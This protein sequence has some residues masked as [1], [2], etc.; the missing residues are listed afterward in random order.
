MPDS[1]A[2]SEQRIARL[3]LRNQMAGQRGIAVRA[4]AVYQDVR[5]RLIIGLL[6]GQ[7]APADQFLHIGMVGGAKRQ[8]GPPE[9]VDARVARVYPV[10]VALR[11][12]QKGRNRAVGLLLGRDRGQPDDDM[13]LLHDAREQVQRVV[14][15]GRVALEQLPRCHHHLVGGFAPAAAPAHAIGDHRQ[16]AALVPRVG[17]LCHLVL[18]MFPVTFVDGGG[19]GQSVGFAH[20]DVVV[21]AGHAQGSRRGQDK[22]VLSTRLYHLLVSPCLRPR[23]ETRFSP[24]LRAADGATARAH[25]ACG[26]GCADGAGGHGGRGW[27]QGWGRGGVGAW[28][29]RRRWRTWWPGFLPRAACWRRPMRIFNRDRGRPGWPWPWRGPWPPA[30][31]WWWRRAPGWARPF[32]TWF[33]RCSV[34]SGFCC[35]R[36]PRCCKTSCSRATCPAWRGRWACPCAWLCSRAAPAICACTAWNWRARMP[37][38]KS[39]AW[40]AR[41]PACRTGRAT[42]WRGIWRN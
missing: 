11:V 39:L 42:R 30:A 19:G 20:A 24:T 25:R 41:W 17:D 2:A 18:L 36:P 4:Q 35:P 29:R 3:Q 15:I 27:S 1:V 16:H 10:A 5:L 31:A 9:M 38:P 34:A 23:L 22:D 6:L 12:D 8:F 37:W 26:P 33:R 14:G 28:M 21:G 32:P 13:G 40:R 7:F